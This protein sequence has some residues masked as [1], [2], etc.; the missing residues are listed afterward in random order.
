MYNICFGFL[1]ISSVFLDSLV[2]VY[3]IH[4]SVTMYRMFF[5]IMSVCSIIKQTIDIINIMNI[6][7]HSQKDQKLFIKNADQTYCRM[8]QVE[9]STI[10]STFIKL[11]IVFVY[12]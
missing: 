9:H 4:R 12:F 10:L 1:L 7:Y 6:Q 5:L 3:L 2:S 8:L 11:P